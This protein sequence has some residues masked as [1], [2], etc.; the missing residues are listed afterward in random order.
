MLGPETPATLFRMNASTSELRPRRKGWGP[1]FERWAPWLAA[2]VLVVGIAAA[3]VKFAPN[4]NAAPQVLPKN[5]PAAPVKPKTVPFS[6]TEAAVMFQFIKTAVARQDLAA[7]WKLAGPNIRAGETY[8]E[9]LKGNIA[10]VPYPIDTRHFAPRV[11]IDYSY[12]NDA[13]IELALLPKAGSGV[14]PQYFIAELK[15]LAGADG[16]ARWVVDNWVPRT[17]LAVPKSPEGG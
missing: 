8:K 14:R 17:S 12:S 7:A 4:R 2:L 9:W 5:P 15:K 3:I 1:R 10:V 6:K 16:K 11:K 13:Q